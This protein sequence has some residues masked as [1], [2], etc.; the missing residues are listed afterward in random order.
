M[1]KLVL[2]AAL[3]LTLVH[4]AQA[5]NQTEAKTEISADLS[6]LPKLVE[7]KRAQLITATETGDIAALKPIFDAQQ[8]PPQVSYGEVADPIATLKEFS[9]D[10]EG[11]EVLA[12]LRNALE[13]PY[14]KTSFTDGRTIYIWPYLAAIDV[15][16]L[17]P[18]Q[19]V[20]AYRILPADVAAGLSSDGAY[21]YWSLTI[22]PSGELSTFSL[23]D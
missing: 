14:G 22:E 8:Y 7:Q 23:G 15:T 12:D 10:G 2:A 1:H 16:S 17:T 9:R 20:D 6:A 3:A 5:Q 4:P 21:Y 13:M 18:G 11:V 19:L